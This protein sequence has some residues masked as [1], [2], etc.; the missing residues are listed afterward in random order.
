MYWLASE[1]ETL[2]HG[3]IK[4][5]DPRYWTLNFP[6][7]MMAAATTKG[8]NTLRV[9]LV[10]YEAHNLAGIIWE[11]ADTYD[12]PLLRYEES[13]DYSRVK[14]SFRW[15]SFGIRTLPEVYG[16]TL[17][18]EGR[19]AQGQFR[20]WYVRLWN[21][22]TGTAEDA[23]IILDFGN[24]SGGFLLPSEADPVYPADISR[25]FISMVPPGFD[26]LST[27]PL[28]APQ[29]AWVEIS[30]IK[31]EG[32]GSTLKLGD[33]FVPPH[34]L[35]MANGYDDVF[36]QTPERLLRNSLY[37]GYSG[38]LDHYVGMSH[39]Q[40]LAYD[41]GEGRFIVTQNGAD[42]LNT[43][44]RAWHQDYFTRAKALGMTPIISISFELFDEWTP[45]AW[46]QRTHDGASAQTGYFPPSTLLSPCNQA[47]MDY[48]RDAWLDF[49]ALCPTAHFQIGEPWWW[50][51][52]FGNGA[53]CFYDDATTALFTAETG[54]A[55]PPKHQSIFE[56]VSAEQGVYLDWL[57]GKLG[58]ATLFLRDAVKTAF[59][60][61]P[62]SVLFFTPQVLR[63]DAP[64]LA[65]VNLPGEWAYPA[66]DYFQLEDYD[67]IIAGDWR[68]HEAGLDLV[69]AQLGYGPADAH[70]FAGF[71]I[72]A[73][74]LSV[75]DN[76]ERALSDAR[77][78]G[79]SE[80]FVWAYPQIAR[81][82]FTTFTL[83]EDKDGMG[84]H[85]VRFPLDI[86][87]G[88]SGG[89]LF[90]T[91]ITELASGAEQRNVNWSQSR[92]RYDIA[93]GV[94]GEDDLAEV[95]AFFRARRGRAYGFRF[96][97]WA[98]YTSHAQNKSPSAFD[99]QIGVGD[100]QETQFQLV[101]FYEDYRR[102]IAKPVAESVRIAVGG[103]EVSG[104]SVDG[105][106]GQITFDT[107]PGNGAVITAGFEFD[108]PVRFADD[109][110]NVTLE[111]FRAG[112]I[113]SIGLIE[114]RG[115]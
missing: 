23:Q 49:G 44:C 25:M 59:P 108:V 86:A 81:D 93:G 70:Y 84:F 72:D 114:V 41:T 57:A 22:A 24:L 9:D 29:E 100:G 99:Q 105:L 43:P 66:F 21:Y 102:I 111:S 52:L 55:L 85:D 104:W 89:P 62:V 7:P 30:D 28:P 61:A 101:K 4:R 34:G 14:L 13:R 103:V 90:S 74:N 2:E 3:F 69:I 64:M 32:S 63:N 47:A 12:P 98:D 10:F 88:S 50:Y 48:L 8:S 54:L 19:D 35:R 115:Q 39:Y 27:A 71:A 40:R 18:I 112:D 26:G 5:F 20:G 113:P 33:T 31:V 87:F 79:F 38:L 73:Q 46:K 37:L 91:S 76:I 107:P 17:T 67:H 65:R 95:I 97:D 36:N 45:Q 56:S 53:P 106:S 75:W 68:A 94:R 15:R 80:I 58:E 1:G 11:S 42:V 78:R 6:R 109:L 60:T 77:K 16:P 96:R 51:Q 83:E 92:A 82:G 110:L